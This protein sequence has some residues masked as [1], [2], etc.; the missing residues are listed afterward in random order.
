MGFITLNHCI[1]GHFSIGSVILD[2]PATS[3]KSVGYSSSNAVINDVS[4]ANIC[5]RNYAL[6]F[7]QGVPQIF[8]VVVD[9]FAEKW[10]K[11]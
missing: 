9:P 1:L 6:W 11:R 7:V 10:T 8:H 3:I 2:P 5:Q 4:Q